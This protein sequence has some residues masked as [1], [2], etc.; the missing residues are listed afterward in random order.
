VMDVLTVARMQIAVSLAFHMIFAAIGIGLPLL[1]VLVERQYLKTG[2]KYYKQLAHIWAKA[3]GLLFA[4]GAVSGTALALELG[5]LWPRYMKI[6]GAV[7]GHMFALEGY[8]F[9]IEAIFIGLYLYGWDR[10]R[11]W[12]HWWCG[13]VVAFSG[14][15]SGILV[16]GVNAWMQLPVGFQLEEGRVIVTDP[17][18]IFKQPAWSYMAVHSTL[19]CYASVGFAVAG[20]YAWKW[21]R[22]RRDDYV[23]SAICIAMLVGGISAILQPLSGDFLAKFVFKTQPAKFAA[24]EGHFKTATYAPLRIGGWP[25]VEK[26]ET[27]WAIEI[28][29]GLSFLA[30]HDPSIEV[31]GLD[32]IPKRD[33]P[34]VEL[35]HLSFQIMVGAGTVMIAVT[36]WFYGRWW[37]KRTNL[38]NS[39]SLLW[40]LVFCSPLG[41]IALETGWMVTEIGR[42]PWA[43]NG[44]LRTADAV[45]AADHIHEMFF[46]FMGL[47][48]VL[49]ITVI[50]VLLRLSHSRLL[51]TE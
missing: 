12:A 24:M 35:T 16:L 21:L 41:F 6:T 4:V 19:A 10:L 34:N 39:K 20:I 3:I 45:T 33:W 8:A 9:F 14:M 17:I 42:Q 40:L 37:L 32:R 13:V 48:L 43:I 30:A 28:P 5:L 26:E 51:Q 22:G 46:V 47:Y 31:T 25:N 29:G 1:L 23:R 50:V 36:I 18:A 15:V 11:P 7:V 27:N 2:L 49:T 44:I 38:L